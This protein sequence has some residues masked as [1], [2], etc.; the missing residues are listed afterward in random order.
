MTA[1]RTAA[2]VASV[3]ALACTKAMAVAAAAPITLAWE[4]EPR[5]VDTR[6]AIDANSQYL[7]NL[8]NC[9]LIDFDADG[10]TVPD[11]AKSWTWV[12]P[13]ALEMTLDPA[14]K[15]WDGT[16]VTAAD[17]KATYDF[18]K[19]A[20]LKTPSPRK[21][22]FAKIKSIEAKGDK[23]TFELEE[24]DSTFISNLVVGVLP[25]KLAAQPEITD[26][27]NLVGCGPFK[28]KSQS[29]NGL[30]LEANETY[31]LGAVPKSKAVTIK[32]VKD[33]ATRFAK[34]SKGE[35]DIVQNGVSRDK[36]TDLAKT[37][38]SLAIMK[39][40]GQQT[41]YL[42]FNMKDKIVGNAK[43]RQAIA[44]A[45][46]REK[47]IKFA[48]NGLAVPATTLITPSDP[49]F[50]KG[51]KAPAYD[52]AAAKKI[53]D[54]AGFKEQGG[55]RFALSYKT[56]TDL[57]RIAI[58][59]AIAADLKRVGIDVTVES[60]EWGR[61][62]SDVETGKVQM[63][64]LSWVGFKD[65]DI[66]RFA[67][68]TESFPPNGGNRGWYSNPGLDKLLTEARAA[69]DL[70]TR[71]AAYEKVQKIVSDELPYVFLWH[72]E[73]FAIVNKSVEDFEVYADGRYGA[74]TKAFKK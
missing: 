7:E 22:A 62:K 21:G 69:T 64:S 35:V 13:T 8:L 36:V 19:R 12:K 43:V 72:E 57:T 31:A 54:D 74:L 52:L 56:T 5:T 71:A 63:W 53:L 48:L 16:P 3:L 2:L 42:G 24:P 17:A 23:L 1:R 6:Y 28:F 55:K 47:I 37:N 11:L 61:F 50:D 67:F 51:L 58:A 60:L 14:A 73:V 30:E 45:I 4:A 39:R 15:F 41:T 20:D 34:L 49:F 27:A 46:D 65:P 33:E 59:K 68:A 29:P 18:F 70:K 26:G 10:R 40:A 9:S 32:F 66:Y 25:A 38:P 44:H